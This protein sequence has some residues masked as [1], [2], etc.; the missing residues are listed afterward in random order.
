MDWTK[1]KIAK[2]LSHHLNGDLS[3]AYENRFDM[4]LQFHSPGL[5]P[6]L[7][8]GKAWHILPDGSPAYSERYLK[9]FGFYDGIATVADDSG[10]LHIFPSGQMLYSN[11]YD[12]C[13]NFQGGFC[14][15]RDCDGNYFHVDKNGFPVYKEHWKYAGDFRDGVAVVQD[16]NGMSSHINENGD[17]LHSVWYIDLDVYHKNFARAKDKDGWTHIDL[18]GNP[19]YSRRFQSVEPF[20]NGQ[21]RVERFDGGLEVIDESG[22]AIIELRP[23]IRSDFSE[24]SSDMVGFWKT[25][26]IAT[27]VNTNLLEYLPAKFQELNQKINL[28]PDFT[29][30]LLRG[31]GELHILECKND[32]WQL[33]SKGEF[34][35]K[36]HPLTL[37]DAALEYA[38]PMSE[39][40]K[41][42]DSAV[43][44]HKCWTPPGIF[45]EV[46]SEP[47]RCKSHHRMLQS[48]ALHDYRSIV[49]YLPIQENDKIIDAGGGLGV[50][51][52]YII[53]KFPDNLITV[54]DLPSVV[55]IGKEQNDKST[56][57][58]HGIDFFEP[59]EIQANVI[60][61]ARVLHDWDDPDALKI[62]KNCR[63]ALLEGGKICLIEMVM[64]EHG[65]S[66]GLCD[67][68]LLMATGGKER[69]VKEY[70]NLFEEAGFR[71][72]NVS[73]C[74]SLLS[75]I[76][77]V[78]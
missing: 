24:L 33:T 54:I 78:I 36:N 6:V 31:L 67:L 49:D 26:A 76:T 74:D 5:A 20:Y 3:P 22:N 17:I 75:I 12:W 46:A 28:Y 64:S 43:T 70:S 8:S 58:W 16:S 39:M 69:T 13:G 37:A 25:Q 42:L 65:V 2:E 32:V 50:L 29:L 57:R 61:L 77:G 15:V 72:D 4:V 38:G 21:A 60:C 73:I 9:T 19:L 35:K 66:G 53:E 11:R 52:E 62:L 56:I 23:A 40:W 41:R 45:K 1:Y 63:E 55:E 27:A 47:E 7:K 71:V 18:Q 30:R 48:Y 14:T 59:W 51:S 10:W 34:L 44:G 68:H